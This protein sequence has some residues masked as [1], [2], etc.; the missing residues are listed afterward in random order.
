M[1]NKSSL[2]KYSFSHSF[3]YFKEENIFGLL[4]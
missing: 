3:Q 4:H 1:E 2:L